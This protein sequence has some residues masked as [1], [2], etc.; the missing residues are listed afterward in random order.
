MITEGG[1]YGGVTIISSTHLSLRWKRIDLQKKKRIEK[2][3]KVYEVQKCGCKTG[4]NCSRGSKL[5][6]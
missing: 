5:W 1:Q 3:L 6:K 4:F 2:K